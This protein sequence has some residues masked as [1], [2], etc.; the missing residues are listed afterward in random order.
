MGAQC[1]ALGA[2]ITFS[3]QPWYAAYVS[4]TR[5]WGLSPLDD[6]VLAGVLMWVPAG[7]AYLAL[8]LVLFGVWLRPLPSSAEQETR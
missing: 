1:T 2:L 6:Q 4:T 8:A 5:A 3:A 7:F